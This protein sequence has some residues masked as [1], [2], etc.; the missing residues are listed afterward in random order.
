M[1]P[2]LYQYWLSIMMSLSTASVELCGP[3]LWNKDEIPKTKPMLKTM[4]IEFHIFKKSIKTNQMEK[5]KLNSNQKSPSMYPVVKPLFG[6][7]RR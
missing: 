6:W 7:W 2:V 3:Q 5:Q 4:R 1:L